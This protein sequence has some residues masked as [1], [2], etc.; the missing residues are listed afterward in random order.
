MS[1]ILPDVTKTC[2]YVNNNV[3]SFPLIILRTVGDNL[4]T[5]YKHPM[6]CVMPN[7]DYLFSLHKP[8]QDYDH[9]E[10]ITTIADKF[11]NLI[12][13]DK[14]DNYKVSYIKACRHNDI[15]IAP[16]TAIM[17][18]DNY[19]HRISGM[20]K[21]KNSFLSSYRYSV[22]W[23]GHESKFD[24]NF[25]L[26]AMNKNE[27]NTFTNPNNYNFFSLPILYNYNCPLWYIRENISWE[28]S[29][30][31]E[32]KYNGYT[33]NISDDYKKYI[34][35]IIDDDTAATNNDYNKE[36]DSA[37]ISNDKNDTKYTWDDYKKD[38]KY[39]WDDSLTIEKI[40]TAIMKACPKLRLSTDEDK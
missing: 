9:F 33:Y 11:C 22:S 36:N 30:S 39:T 16:T 5:N 26:M 31:L 6:S 35:D 1:S 25:D 32:P 34:T 40:N 24:V 21:R 7:P 14:K 18:H 38:T 15:S 8:G 37:V 27:L 4:F 17:V 29:L 12:R 2:D 3:I 28:P 20:P 13:D 23:N 10:L 19:N